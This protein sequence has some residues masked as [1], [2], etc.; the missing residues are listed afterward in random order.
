MSRFVVYLRIKAVAM[1]GI[2]AVFF[3]FYL[4][5]LG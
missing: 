5:R 3:L 2:G 4:P 1:A